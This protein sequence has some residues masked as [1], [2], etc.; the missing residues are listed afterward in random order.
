MAVLFPAGEDLVYLVPNKIFPPQRYGD[1][2]VVLHGSDLT[3]SRVT[4]PPV[5]KRMSFSDSAMAAA[6]G[7]L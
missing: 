3:C 4:M 5:H 6:Q 2:A 1:S 7:K